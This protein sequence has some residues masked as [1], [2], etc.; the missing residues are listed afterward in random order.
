MDSIIRGT[1]PTIRFTFQAV[2][3]ANITTA[4][5]TV[6]QLAAD[7]ITREI[8]TAYI[9]ATNNSIEW[10]LTQEETLRLGIGRN[11]CVMCDWKTADGVRGRSKVAEYMIA[12]SGK[13]E[14]I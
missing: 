10:E 8:D 13:N 14:V 1:T 11:A 7:V 12:P 5:M 2:N 9:D 6:K 4:Y 3:V